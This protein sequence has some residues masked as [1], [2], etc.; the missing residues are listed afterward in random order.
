MIPH[1]S[2]PPISHPRV[3]PK[4]LG[5]QPPRALPKLG[6]CLGTLWG[7]CWGL[8][9]PIH[10]SPYKSVAVS[11]HPMGATPLGLQGGMS[12]W[13]AFGGGGMSASPHAPMADFRWGGFVLMSPCPH[14]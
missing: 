1:D 2:P 12:P 8:S 14:G 4:S 3:T 6:D 11:P 5:V 7:L 10:T 13:L 9:I